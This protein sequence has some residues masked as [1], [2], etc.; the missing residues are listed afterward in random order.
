MDA[1]RRDST[2]LRDFAVASTT[3]CRQKR[4]VT[5]RDGLSQAGL[6]I[7]SSFSFSGELTFSGQTETIEFCNGNWSDMPEVTPVDQ[8][9]LA[10]QNVNITSD[11]SL[12]T[13]KIKGETNNS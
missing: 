5:S 4:I 13:Y 3:D 10:H 6:Y 9:E 1:K 12:S 7:R 2:Q 8:P 11:S